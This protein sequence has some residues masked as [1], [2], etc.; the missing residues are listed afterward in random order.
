[1]DFEIVNMRIGGKGEIHTPFFAAV[2]VEGI[3]V[4][5]TKRFGTVQTIRYYLKLFTGLGRHIW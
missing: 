1:M 2:T 4:R 5:R 3:M